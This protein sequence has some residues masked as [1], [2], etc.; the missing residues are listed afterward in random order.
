MQ[1]R[2]GLGAN[3]TAVLPTSLEHA[4]MSARARALMATHVDEVQKLV[5]ALE[6]DGKSDVPLA[7]QAALLYAGVMA[8][9]QQRQPAKARDAMTRLLQITSEDPSALRAAQWLAADTERRLGAPAACVAKVP[10]H[11]ADRA[12]VL[13]LAQCRLDVKQTE[14]TRDAI[15]ALQIW[16]GQFPRD[17]LAWDLVSQA[18]AQAGDKLRSLRADAQSRAVRWDEQGAIDRLRAAQELVKRMVKE[19]RL[20]RAGNM[21]ASI[22]DS[23]LRALE[24]QRRE[25]LHPQN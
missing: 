6:Q 23:R 25:L 8:Y 17:G 3:S 13:L 19:G 4:M 9:T 2:L 18:Y 7:K 10:A 5:L 11:A 1:S 22:I 20:D 21:E 12:R 16:L 15:E 24:A 14:A